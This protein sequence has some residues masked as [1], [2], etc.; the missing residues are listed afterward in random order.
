VQFIH[1]KLREERRKELIRQRKLAT[2]PPY[3]ALRKLAGCSMQKAASA[4][5]V[6]LTTIWNRENGIGQSDLDL[7]DFYLRE[8]QVGLDKIKPF[9]DVQI[10]RRSMK[11]SIGRIIHFVG[12]TG[13]P[14][15]PAVVVAVHDAEVVDLVYFMVPA[16]PQ[17]SMPMPNVPHSEVKGSVSWHWPER[18]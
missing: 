3:R 12:E 10:E 14:H 15:F 1:R 2:W 5:G 9:F 7:M 8:I 16:N 4:T 13:G 17:A 6:S 18:E 11:P